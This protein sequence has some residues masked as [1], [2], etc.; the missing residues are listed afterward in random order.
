ML[1]GKPKLP[2]EPKM[3]EWVDSSMQR[4][5]EMFGSE[6]ITWATTVVPTEACFPDD[7][8]GTAIAAELLFSRVCGYM[9]VDRGAVDLKICL[10][11][12]D[13]QLDALMDVLPSMH[14]RTSGAAGFYLG[15]KETE[16]QI[17]SIDKR[18]L[19]DIG[20]IIATMAHELGHVLLL[21]GGRIDRDAH[22]ME[23]LTD[24]LTVFRGIGIF[25][26]N[27][28]FN[29][30][31]HSDGRRRGWSVERLGYLSEQTYG[32]ALAVYANIRSERHP[33]WVK[34]LKLNVREYFKQSTAVLDYERRHA[35]SLRR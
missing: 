32:Y 15:S 6:A 23:A 1:W 33:S 35:P 7:W 17:I 18:N 31:Q 22:D 21:G 20:K 2:V 13:Q 19:L 16:R 27:N 24:L 10:D 12:D 14:I 25:S 30:E 29:F 3:R 11:D 5:T 8:D 26:A 4:F 9:G 28:A 34:Y